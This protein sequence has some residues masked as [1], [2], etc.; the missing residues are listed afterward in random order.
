MRDLSTDAHNAEIARGV[1]PRRS[2]FIDH[3]DRDCDDHR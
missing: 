3:P 1:P 2:D